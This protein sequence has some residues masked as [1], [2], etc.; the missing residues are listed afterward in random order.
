MTKQTLQATGQNPLTG[1]SVVIKLSRLNLAGMESITVVQEM[2]D[3][4]PKSKY[5]VLQ[6]TDTNLDKDADQSIPEHDPSLD[7]LTDQHNS[8]T[9]TVLYWS[10]E[11]GKAAANAH[12]QLKE[13]KQ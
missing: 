7:I 9:D 12:E 3:S 4:M 8:S 13:P 2:L 1:A 11:D 5:S 10:A 6:E